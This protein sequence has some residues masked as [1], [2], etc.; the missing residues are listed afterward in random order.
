VVGSNI[1][2]ILSV[3]GL[4]A[5]F[6]PGDLRVVSAMLSFDI[7]VM[8]GFVLPQLAVTLVVLAVRHWR[9]VHPDNRI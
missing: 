2:N 1:F 5:S 7:P 4:S 3:L 8:G 6:A 9:R